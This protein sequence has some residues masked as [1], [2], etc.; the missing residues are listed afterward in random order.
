M[1]KGFTL[2]E[3]LIVIS[4]AAIISSIIMGYFINFKKSESLSLDTDTIVSILRQ[5]R[6][7]T[8]SSK[9]AS[10]YGVHFSGSN[11]I[12]FTGSEYLENNPDNVEF[13]LGLID[14][15]FV[16]N[17][18]GGSNNVVFE[19]MT[20]ETLNFGTVSILSGDQTK[21]ITIYKTGIIEI[22]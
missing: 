16:L 18:S 7:Q 12:I 13:H 5:A 19:R 17:L 14:A 21:N 15:S 22:Q 1:K 8:L 3:I 10:Q 11:I 4:I 9:N 2:I 6:S 20:G